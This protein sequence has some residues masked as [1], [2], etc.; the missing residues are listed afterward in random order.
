[1]VTYSPSGDERTGTFHQ[2]RVTKYLQWIHGVCFKIPGR[3]RLFRHNKMKP[4]LWLENL[5]SCSSNYKEDI[6]TGKTFSW[7][8]KCA[9]TIFI[10]VEGLMYWMSVKECIINQ[11]FVIKSPDR[12]LYSL[13]CSSCLLVSDK[14]RCVFLLVS[15]SDNCS[16]KSIWIIWAKQSLL[17]KWISHRS[18]PIILSITQIYFVT[19]ETKSSLS[20]NSQLTGFCSCDCCFIFQEIWLK[21]WKSS[22]QFVHME[23]VICNWNKIFAIFSE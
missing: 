5:G 19:I 12:A 20:R 22:S 7:I 16:Q 18:L 6:Q 4:Q 11:Y 8:L 23:K 21:W 15:L 10:Y 14:C 1:M 3:L 17:S 2:C 13:C 9:V